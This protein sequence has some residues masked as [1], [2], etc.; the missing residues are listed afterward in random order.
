MP[1]SRLGLAARRV[2]HAAAS[3][4]PIVGIQ[5]VAIKKFFRNSNQVAVSRDGIEVA[6]KHE[7]L[8]PAAPP[9]KKRQ[10]GIIRVI[11]VNPVEAGI[12]ELDLVQRALLLVEPVEIAHKLKQ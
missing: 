5:G 4:F 7:V 12:V 3:V 10:H 8:C 11:G 9:A 2:N 6:K 1:G